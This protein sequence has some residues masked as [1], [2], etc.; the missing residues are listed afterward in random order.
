MVENFKIYLVVR[1]WKAKMSHAE[2]KSK[3]FAMSSPFLW[4]IGIVQVDSEAPMRYLRGMGSLGLVRLRKAL[5]RGAAPRGRSVK[6]MRKK[7]V[8]SRP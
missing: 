4:R 8:K 6:R 3:T 7:I 2:I 5:P 1:L